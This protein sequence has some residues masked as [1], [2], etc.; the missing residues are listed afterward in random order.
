MKAFL[1]WSGGKDSAL[2]LQQ[3]RRQGFLVEALVTM[4]S[5]EEGRVSTHGVRKELVERQAEA[6]GL[7]LHFVSLPLR[8][9]M[10]AYE[11]AVNKMNSSL[12]AAGF[13]HAL[14]GDLFLED[15]KAYREKLYAADGLQTAFPIWKK[16]GQ[17]LLKEFFSEGWK[18]IVVSVDGSKLDASFCGREL[19]NSFIAD[20]P[21]GTDPCG[22]NG[23]YHSFVYDGPPFRQP[24]N[25]AKCLIRTDN[26]PSS[27]RPGEFTS[28]HYCD[29]LPA[30]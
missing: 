1:N 5:L 18:A 6:I 28:F 24:V 15:L 22:E 26:S 19:E 3:A 23:E 12:K 30:S 11:S 2:C 16:D 17:V 7:P 8:P 25:F 14:S 9:S 27:G 10:A 4:I 20:L 29:L 13:T 21:A